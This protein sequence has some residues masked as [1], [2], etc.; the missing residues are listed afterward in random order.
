MMERRVLGSEQRCSV[1]CG[2]VVPL[3]VIISPSPEIRNRVIDPH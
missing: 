3:V 2:I 1:D